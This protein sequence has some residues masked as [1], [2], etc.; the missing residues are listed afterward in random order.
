MEEVLLGVDALDFLAREGLPVLRSTLAA[1]ADHAAEAAREIGFPVAL[2]VSSPDVVH[3]TETGGIR[4]LLKD[5]K[6]V[7]GAFADIVASFSS[8]YPEKRLDGV[9]VQR[10]GSGTELIVGTME[11]AQ[12]GQVLMFGLGGIFVEALDEVSFR[13]I[14]LA[15]WDAKEMME[16]LKGSAVLSRPRGEKVDIAAVEVLLLQ[17][18]KL[19]ERC[20]Y[21]IEMDLNPVFVS[22]DGVA[23]CDA[24]IKVA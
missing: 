9:I 19:A 4:T 2:K 16:E 15:P 5:E 14:P 11:D 10:Q 20:P 6:E 22:S 1:D 8:R 3:K 23:V 17:V 24:R 7:R 12:F 21:I 18:S 13:L